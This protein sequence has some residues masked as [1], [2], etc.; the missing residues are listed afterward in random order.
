MFTSI[1]GAKKAVESCTNA[2]RK[3][4]SA[5]TDDS[6]EQKVIENHRTLG[7]I[8][9][10]IVQTLPEMGNRTGLAVKGPDDK[11]AVPISAGQI[12]EAYNLAAKSLIAELDAKWTDD[13][14]K[15]E[16]DMYGEKWPRGMT[17]LAL[18]DHEIHHRGQM[19]I[20]MRQAGLRVPGVF[21]PSYEEWEN[22]GMKAPEI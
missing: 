14:L 8:A 18:L 2:T 11:Q 5:L 1:D 10:H 21:G 6:L 13:D 15:K 19:T 4:M 22:Y 12:A 17:L 20:L 16:D 3:I 9:W 7:R